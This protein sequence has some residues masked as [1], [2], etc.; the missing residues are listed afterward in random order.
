MEL[1][2]VW[3]NV[4]HVLANG[5]IANPGQLLPLLI[6][7]FSTFRILWIVYK[8]CIL[9]RRP[10]QSECH[11]EQV[12]LG[13][14]TDNVAVTPP[15]RV[16]TASEGQQRIWW[17]RLLSAWLPWLG[18]F[19]SWR[20]LGG[21]PLSL[22]MRFVPASSGGGGAPEKGIHSTLETSMVDAKEHG[23]VGQQERRRR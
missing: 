4:A 23:D 7:I 19:E 20:S 16:E 15:E 8:E 3:N 17:H 14:R 6:G 2:L 5:G 9:D 13:G 22:A 18:C 1:T 21:L 11:E 10:M 12:E